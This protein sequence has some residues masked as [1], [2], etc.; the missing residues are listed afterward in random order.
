M[1]LRDFTRRMGRANAAYYR[2]SSGRL[3]ELAFARVEAE[4]SDP[5]W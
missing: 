1:E 3:P 4:G 5:V 2:L